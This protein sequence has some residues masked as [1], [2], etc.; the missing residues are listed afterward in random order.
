MRHSRKECVIN[1]KQMSFR[2]NSLHATY[3][4]HEIVRYLRMV[5]RNPLLHPGN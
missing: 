3:S 1:N 5:T 2:G 4:L